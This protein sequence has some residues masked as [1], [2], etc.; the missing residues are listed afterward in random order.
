MRRRDLFRLA[1]LFGP[2]YHAHGAKAPA[3]RFP[4]QP[5]ERLAVASYPFRKFIA[6]SQPLT[7]FPAMVAERYNVHNVELLGNHF[8]SVQPAYLNELRKA[9]EKAGVH[10]INLPVS[11]RTSLYDP[12]PDKRSTAVADARK[13]VDTASTL[14]CPS[15]RVHVR[16]VKGTAP[17][18]ALGIQSLREVAAYAEQK[19][20]VVNLEN[21]DPK[22]EE[23]SFIVK[24]IDGVKSPYLHA[25]P[26]FCNSMLI[27]PEQ[28]NY[29]SVQAMFAR[30]YNI[31]H[32]KDS[33]VEAGKIYRVDVDRT[34]AIAK[35]AGYRGYFSMEWEGEGSP[36]EGTRKLIDM[37]LRNLQG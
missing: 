23:A 22:S 31:C 32:V 14:N 6:G 19:N 35:A 17:D 34:F 33:E 9:A 5:R 7:S 8:V 27:G 3:I 12:D 15:I 4:I 1:A 37:S 25:L 16:A 11:P 30:A 18:V 21:D 26:D 13:W 24:L 20:V 36:Y 29:D 10:I 28:Y 2:T